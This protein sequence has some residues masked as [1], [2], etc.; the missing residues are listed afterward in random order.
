[1]IK[2]WVSHSSSND[3]RNFVLESSVSYS[4]PVRDKL[5][6]RV[7]NRSYE[8]VRSSSGFVSYLSYSWTSNDIRFFLIAFVPWHWTSNVSHISL[9]VLQAITLFD[10]TESSLFW[11][12]DFSFES[13]STS[14]LSFHV[15]AALGIVFRRRSFFS[16]QFLWDVGTISNPVDEVRICGFEIEYHLQFSGRIINFVEDWNF[17]WFLFGCW[18]DSIFT[19][20]K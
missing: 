17:E 6:K 16:N 14:S 3:L 5:F 1:M 12:I 20:S 15:K 8:L 10:M 4:F 13:L 2:L 9:E 11:R 7:R 18:H 19:G